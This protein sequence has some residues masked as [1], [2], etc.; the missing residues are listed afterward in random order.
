VRGV[1]LAVPYN[2]NATA[3]GGGEGE[4]AGGGQQRAPPPQVQCPPPV[5]AT[6][7]VFVTDGA[8]LGGAGV[9]DAAVCARGV[10]AA[11]GQLTDVDCGRFV[12]GRVVTVVH[13]GRA[14]VPLA[15]CGVQ[16]LGGE[17]LSAA[18]AMAPGAQAAA[19]PALLP[20][21]A[22]AIDS[23]AGTCLATDAPGEARWEL[24]LDVSWA[25][26]LWALLRRWRLPASTRAGRCSSAEKTGG[27]MHCLAGRWA[28]PLTS[29][30]PESLVFCA[31]HV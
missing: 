18:G 4:D 21:F 12:P 31:G 5:N 19:P 8:I 29:H 10:A 17:E 11:P 9:A 25:P 2:C 30:L 14:P 1:R 22:A 3:G 15:L 20:R 24:R 16:L 6:L 28:Y 13:Q 7:D 23:R 27:C 26:L